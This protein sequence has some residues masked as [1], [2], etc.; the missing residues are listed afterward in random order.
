M[1]RTAENESSC[2]NPS[3]VEARS[4]SDSHDFSSNDPSN[5]SV[6]DDTYLKMSTIYNTPVIQRLRIA[7]AKR[8]NSQGPRRTESPWRGS[9]RK[10]Q[11]RDKVEQST[12]ASSPPSLEIAESAQLTTESH[13]HDR[14]VQQTTIL[15]RPVQQTT[16]LWQEIHDQ[17]D[18][19]SQKT[20]IKS[21]KHK[22]QLRGQEK[23]DVS[24]LAEE[25]TRNREIVEQS[26]K[27]LR[28][29]LSR[30]R[31]SEGKLEGP[32]DWIHKAKPVLRRLSRSYSLPP[33]TENLP[34]EHKQ[35]V[36]KLQS[37]QTPKPDLHILSRTNIQ[38]AKSYQKRL[39]SLAAVPLL[40]RHDETKV[41]LRRSRRGSLIT[42]TP[43][44]RKQQFSTT[45]ISTTSI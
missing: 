41:D 21:R 33:R 36:S 30:R 38:H 17:N 15:D 28:D 3:N 37:I 24:Y 26:V 4:C 43:T 12:G 6:F 31:S 27:S 19:A 18:L 22:Q 42:V 35:N 16:I 13:N 20:D 7:S 8:R 44:L 45:S 9:F 1:G 10:E 14:A 40:T 23:Y 32:T 39:P 2:N 11:D 25:N 29:K 5:I 34:S